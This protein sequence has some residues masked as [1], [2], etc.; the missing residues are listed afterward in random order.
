MNQ[1]RQH[2]RMKTDM[3]TFSSLLRLRQELSKLILKHTERIEDLLVRGT[4]QGKF[5][6][7]LLSGL[8]VSCLGGWFFHIS[9][10]PHR[11][12]RGQ[13]LTPRHRLRSLT[14]G[15]GKKS[16]KDGWPPPTVVPEKADVESLRTNS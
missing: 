11:T 13:V 1:I 4:A 8:S 12:P 5:Y 10:P 14:G 3:F 7:L 6:E 2:Q 9:D 16:S 15:R